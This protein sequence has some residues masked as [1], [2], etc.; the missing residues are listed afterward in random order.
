MAKACG[1]VTGILSALALWCTPALGAEIAVS[2]DVEIFGADVAGQLARPVAEMEE[3]LTRRGCHAFSRTYWSDTTPLRVLH[4]E[5]RCKER[6]EDGRL[7][8]R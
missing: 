5:V 3:E 4:V 7:A 2:R 1:R 8:F 6:D